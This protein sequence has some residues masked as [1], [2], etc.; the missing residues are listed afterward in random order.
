M[1][2]WMNAVLDG[3]VRVADTLD[4]WIAETVSGFGAAA[5]VVSETVGRVE[6][7]AMQ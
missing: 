1:R 7:V 2:N 4:D 5:P 6:E 3:A